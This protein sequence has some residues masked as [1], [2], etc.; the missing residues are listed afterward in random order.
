MIIMTTITG[1][2][3]PCKSI[4]SLIVEQIPTFA[5]RSNLVREVKIRLQISN[6]FYNKLLYIDNSHS[7]R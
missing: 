7:D 3:R 5:S 4:Y 2:L 1:N 6:K